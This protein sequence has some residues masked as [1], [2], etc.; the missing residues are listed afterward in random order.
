MEKFLKNMRDISFMPCPA[1]RI[2]LN[3]LLES[4]TENLDYFRFFSRIFTEI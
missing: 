3:F 2:A 4:A 1:L